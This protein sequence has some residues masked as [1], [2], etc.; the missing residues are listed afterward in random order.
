MGTRFNN[1]LNAIFAQKE[2]EILM[3][4]EINSERR[5]MVLSKKVRLKFVGNL[6]Q[7]LYPQS[8]LLW[9]FPRKSGDTNIP[10]GCGRI[11]TYHVNEL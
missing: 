7:K 9:T 2:Y 5:Y 8:H 4:Y 10:L 1:D 11:R 3:G 6:Y